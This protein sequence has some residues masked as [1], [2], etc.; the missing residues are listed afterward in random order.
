MALRMPLMHNTLMLINPFPGMYMSILKAV[1]LHWLCLISHYMVINITRWP[2]C[3]DHTSP[4][5]IYFILAQCFLPFPRDIIVK[6]TG[7]VMD[8]KHHCS[9]LV[10]KLTDYEVHTRTIFSVKYFPLKYLRKLKN[11]NSTADFSCYNQHC[12]Y[13]LKIVHRFSLFSSDSHNGLS[14]KFHRFFFLFHE[15]G[16]SHKTWP[17]PPTILSA[18]PVLYNTYTLA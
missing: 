14:T 7:L 11:K 17:L 3:Q 9:T 13:T 1:F 16:W 6:D 4:K 2:L 8:N 15:H 5:P 18:P 12:V 10:W